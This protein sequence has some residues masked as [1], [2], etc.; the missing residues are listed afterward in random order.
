MK[1][2]LMATILSC[3]ILPVVAQSNLKN[4][5][6]PK[7]GEEAIRKMS[8]DTKKFRESFKIV[9]SLK[10]E[11]YGVNPHTGQKSIVKV[12]NGI[13]QNM[14]KNK[15]VVVQYMPSAEQAELYFVETDG[16]GNYF[17]PQEFLNEDGV[18]FTK[19][20]LSERVL[21]ILDSSQ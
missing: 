19:D 15:T 6:A 4:K 17:Y 7:Y 11:K 16:R 18:F 8:N 12:Y 20:K 1:K 10:E 13:F 21:Q 2:I 3:S 9:L 14:N 5:E